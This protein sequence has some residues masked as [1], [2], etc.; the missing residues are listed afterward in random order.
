MQVKVSD[1]NQSITLAIWGMA[2]FQCV[3]RIR[4]S[5]LQIAGV[6]SAQI[7]LVNG[8]A[9]VNYDPA[10]TNPLAL[11]LAVGAAGN[12]GPHEFRAELLF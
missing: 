9:H 4:E 5:L 2:C 3:L 7:D 6:I 8:L 1:P 11:V 12:D 10:R